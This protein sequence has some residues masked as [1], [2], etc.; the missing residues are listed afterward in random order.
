MSRRHNLRTRRKNVSRSS[1]I[2]V[3]D[4]AD[5]NAAFRDVLAHD[6]PALLDVVTA[7]N[8]LSM[9]P[10]IS[11][12]EVKGFSLYVLSAVMSGR[13]DDHRFGEGKSFATMT[14]HLAKELASFVPAACWY[15]AGTGKATTLAHISNE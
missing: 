9:P 6:G 5:V 8:E 2:R 15:V 7:A 3:D 1:A 4:P 12:E 13:G 14:W 10:T 11:A